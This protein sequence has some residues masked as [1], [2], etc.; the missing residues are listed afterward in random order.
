MRVIACIL[1]PERSTLSYD[2]TV[3]VPA[4]FDDAD[5]GATQDAIEE[6]PDEAFLYLL[7]NRF[8]WPDVPHDAA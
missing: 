7:P 3:E 2:A 1:P 4:R 8:S 6:L 5:K